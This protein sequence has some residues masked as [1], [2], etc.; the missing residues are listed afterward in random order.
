[1][2]ADTNGQECADKQQQQQSWWFASRGKTE[3]LFAINNKI[4]K[5]VEN[6]PSTNPSLS[7][8]TD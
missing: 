4:Q 5:N 8:T 2:V 1:M 7:F 6:Y 3:V